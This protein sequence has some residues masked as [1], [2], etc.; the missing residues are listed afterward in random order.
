MGLPPQSWR[1]PWIWPAAPG[2]PQAPA[3]RKA[4]ALVLLTLAIAPIVPLPMQAAA[5][6]PTPAIAAGS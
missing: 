6:T 1:S 4:A 2:A 3:R 5:I